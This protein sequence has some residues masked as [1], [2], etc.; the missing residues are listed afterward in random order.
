[1]HK[2]V[3]ARGSTSLKEKRLECNVFALCR[4]DGALHQGAWR[5]SGVLEAARDQPVVREDLR[6]GG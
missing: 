6:R 1:M 4:R 3:V 2:D 5:L